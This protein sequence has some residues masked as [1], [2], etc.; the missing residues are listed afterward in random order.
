MEKIYEIKH[1]S[2]AKGREIRVF[3]EDFGVS[4][5]K[6]IKG[7][8]KIR[9]VTGNPNNPVINETVEFGIEADTVTDAFKTFDESFKKEMDFQKAEY[10]K[11]MREKGKEI[12]TATSMPSHTIPF[13][14]K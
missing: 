9:M 7:Y 13:K 1:Y 5:D 4:T 2:D 11:A 12:V 10:E 8:A 3:N 6:F 14:I